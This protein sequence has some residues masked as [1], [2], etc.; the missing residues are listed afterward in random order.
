MNDMNPEEIENLRKEL[1]FAV[2]AAELRKNNEHSSEGDVAIANQIMKGLEEEIYKVATDQVAVINQAAAESNTG[3]PVEEADDS[4]TTEEPAISDFHPGTVDNPFLYDASKY[5]LQKFILTNIFVA[6]KNAT[7]QQRK[8]DEFI[9]CVRRDVGDAVVDQLG[10]IAAIHHSYAEAVIPEKVKGWLVEV[11]A[12]QYARITSSICSLGEYLGRNSNWLSNASRAELVNVRGIG[13]KTA[14]M[15]LMYT[16]RNYTGACLD[17]H[18]LK[19]MR[20][21]LNIPNVPL[22]TPPLKRD[23]RKLEDIFIFH[24][25]KLNRRI[26]E[27]DFEIWSKYRLQPNTTA[28]APADVAVPA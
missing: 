16:R 3:A 27:L 4:N 15:F 8:L 17:T 24:A 23:Y 22:S 18:I 25:K 9:K 5:D 12:G 26:A 28:T 21:E 6:G 10:P 11:K 2:Q 20:E 7:V 19:Y 14:S 13:Y 1:E